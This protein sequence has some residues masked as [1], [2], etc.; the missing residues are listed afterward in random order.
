MNGTLAWFKSSYSNMT[1]DNCVEVLRSG[2]REVRVRDSK[3]ITG[4]ELTVP[5]P[6]WTASG[7]S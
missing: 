7:R 5:T 6:S 4:P 3:R 2:P 1:G